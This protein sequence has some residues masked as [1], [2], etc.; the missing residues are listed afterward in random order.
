LERNRADVLRLAALRWLVWCGVF[1]LTCG[2]VVAQTPIATLTME[3]VDPPNWWAGMPKPMLLVRGEGLGGAMFSVSDRGL[4]VERV[5][6]SENGHWAQVWLSASPAKPETVTL[7]AR[8]GGAS[9]EVSYVF[10]ARRPASDGFAGFSSRDVMYLIMTDRFADGDL[11][12]DGVKGKSAADSAEAVEERAKPRGWHGGDLRGVAQHLDY[13]QQLGVTAVW[14]TP[15]YENHEASSYHGYGATD[16]YKVD[17]HYGSLDDLKALAAGLHAR[18][19]KLVL[20]TVPNHVGP[21]NPWVKDQPTP[22]WFHGTAA[23][24]LK[25]E[26]NFAALIDPHAPER[27]RV[28]T[29]EGWFADTLPDMNTESPAVA[30]YLRQNAVWWIEETGADALRIDT[31]PYVNREFWNEF[32]GELKTLYP[33]V[34]EVG[35]VF[36]GDPVIT[37]SFAGGVTRA[38]VDTK[39][40]TPFDFPTYFA[41]QNVF[42]KGAPMSELAEV[43]GHDSLYPHPE[44]LVSFIGNHDTTRFVTAAKSESSLELAMAYVLTTRGTP[45]IYSGDE[46]AMPGGGDPDDR[47]DFPGGFAGMANSA[48]VAGGRTAEEARAF[49]WVASL[50][51]LRRKHDALACGAEQVLASSADWI[52][53]LRDAG[54]AV[55]G[56]CGASK[57]RV[58]VAVHRD[59]K[60][61]GGAAAALDVKM[62]QTWMEGCRLGDAEVHTGGSSGMVSGDLLQLKAEGDAVWIAACQ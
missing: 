59:G 3:K 10:G 58:V 42:A 26:T 47:H 22:D 9:A 44:R 52:V 1:A 61:G 29:L 54:H 18:G 31:F 55:D 32:N 43:L 5:V 30:Q 2:A 21:G 15:V 49:D 38:G 46:I 14:T 53:Y 35:E 33:R 7:R 28:G 25:A 13:L 6:A 27:D 56:G 16:L 19:M 57:E 41:L 45:Q 12:N 24:H 4:K 62:G 50:T 40:Y 17:E 48:F 23:H 11:S 34:T 36:N 8:R 20:D 37:S 51:A 39:L 60:P